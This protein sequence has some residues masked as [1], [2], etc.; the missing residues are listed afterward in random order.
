MAGLPT[1]T[2]MPITLPIDIRINVRRSAEAILLVTLKMKGIE[3][4]RPRYQSRVAVEDICRIKKIHMVLGP[5]R[6]GKFSLRY[7]RNGRLLS[8]VF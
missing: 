6:L 4:Q 8:S 3:L 2:P 7:D 5:L 1:A